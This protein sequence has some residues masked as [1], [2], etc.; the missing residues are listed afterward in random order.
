MSQQYGERLSYM[1]TMLIEGPQTVSESA[2]AWVYVD[3]Y[4]EEPDYK[5]VSVQPWDH[6]VIQLEKVR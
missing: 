5:V 6:T 1:L 3:P 2:G 4:A